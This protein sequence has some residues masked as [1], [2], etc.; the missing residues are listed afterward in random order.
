MP[1]THIPTD[2][3]KEKDQEIKAI[4]RDDTNFASSRINLFQYLIIGIFLYLLSGFWALQ[5]RDHEYWED[6]A[7][8]N[9]IRFSP[10]PAPRGKI[11]DREGRIIVDNHSSFSLHLSR[12]N[13]KIEHLK[14]I[15]EI[16]RA[17]V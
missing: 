1:V 4:L 5:I 3:E 7:E 2:H 6:L 8:R 10:I 11:F 14:P 12:E 15:C 9:R 16:G 17:H 13:L